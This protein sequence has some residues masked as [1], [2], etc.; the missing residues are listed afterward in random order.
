[1]P[2]FARFR[3]AN[4]KHALARRSDREQLQ[5]R[6]VIKANGVGSAAGVGGSAS[7]ASSLSAAGSATGG[8]GR[9]GTG[10]MSHLLNRANLNKG[11]NRRGRP[12][13]VDLEAQGIYKPHLGGAAGASRELESNMQVRPPPLPTSLRSSRLPRAH[14]ITHS[15]TQP[16]TRPHALLPVP[17]F[18]SQ[19]AMLGRKLS[20]RPELGELQQRGIHKGAGASGSA[21]ADAMRSKIAAGNLSRALDP[22][23]RSSIADL[24]QAGILKPHAP[25]PAAAAAE[26]KLARGLLNRKLSIRPDQAELLSRGIL[27]DSGTAG[28]QGD[29]AGELASL[30]NLGGARLAA[31]QALEKQMMQDNLGRRLSIRPDVDALVAR[32]ILAGG[33]AVG[34]RQDRADLEAAEAEKTVLAAQLNRAMANR[35]SADALQK[36][37]VLGVGGGRGGAGG[38][39]MSGGGGNALALER[40]MIS[41]Q[42]AKALKQRPSKAEVAADK[43]GIFASEAL[44]LG[45]AHAADEASELATLEQLRAIPEI[46]ALLAEGKV[47]EPELR[48]FFSALDAD[49]DGALNFSQFLQL[50]DELSAVVEEME[51]AMGAKAT[52]KASLASS[53]AE[54]M[55]QRPELAE[56]KARG[57]HKGGSSASAM[58]ERNLLVNQLKANLGARPDKSMLTAKGILLQGGAGAEAEGLGIAG[59]AGAT[60]GGGAAGM[61]AQ[62][63][64]SAALLQA[65]LGKRPDLASLKQRG[66]FSETTAASKS[67][68]RGLLANALK[69]QLMSRPDRS[70]LEGR[71][72]VQDHSAETDYVLLLDEVRVAFARCLLLLLASASFVYR[73]D[74]V[75]DPWRCFFVCS[76][77][78]S[79]WRSRC[80]AHLRSSSRW[81]TCPWASKCDLIWPAEGG[82]SGGEGGGDG[83]VGRRRANAKVGRGE[84][85]VRVGWGKGTCC[86]RERAYETLPHQSCAGCVVREAE[87]GVCAR[88]CRGTLHPLWQGA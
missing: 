23:R 3:S 47:E 56:L 53:L 18:R 36:R 73:L 12:S 42:L 85:R 17:C 59:D 79:R 64:N 19:R 5:Q 46:G 82:G 70:E 13:L 9:L 77:R 41:D 51:A 7:D 29:G 20:C 37:G 43:K 40:Q 72:I 48:T 68:E 52:R 61:R 44:A 58:L 33:S 54:A 11:L 57:L 15:P 22:T 49:K 50:M 69:N 80:G 24:E 55:A 86:K 35:P 74:R 39:A 6:G 66:I 10:D 71:G 63:K 31:A 67:L 87:G 27:H 32:G 88:T 2:R 25:N 34:G 1:L 81:P 30:G 4:L 83:K 65:N 75:T 60:G 8:V 45:F 84:T 16:L 38:G 78:F 21:A 28:A 76:L 14:V 62:R 26:T